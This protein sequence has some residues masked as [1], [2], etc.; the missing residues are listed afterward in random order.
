MASPEMKQTK[1]AE[2][3]CM[4]ILSEL[5]DGYDSDLEQQLSAERIHAM[6]MDIRQDENPIKSDDDSK[7]TDPQR[8]RKKLKR[9]LRAEAMTRKEESARTEADFEEVTELW[10]KLDENRERREQYHEV[11]RGDVPLEYGCSPD[12]AIVPGWLSKPSQQAI[13]QGRFLDVVFTQSSELHEMTGHADIAKMLRDLKLE[14]KDLLYLLVVRGW[15][16]AQLAESIGQSDRNV[17]KKKM[18]LLN[19]LQEALYEELS[20]KRNLSQRE[21]Q[22]LAGYKKAALSGTESGEKERCAV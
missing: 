6:E 18:R 19:R 9:E 14:Y 2:Q 15:S 1:Q 10:D 4:R 13:R 16:T 17:R 21:L 11:S 7:L 3:E 12:A 20:G 22:F 5:S 8:Q